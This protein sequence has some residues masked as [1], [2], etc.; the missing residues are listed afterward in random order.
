LFN[1]RIGL[2]TVLVRLR[3]M[4]GE[5]G[6]SS[7]SNGLFVRMF[8]QEFSPNH[9]LPENMLTLTQAKTQS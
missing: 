9:S 8:L 4:A 2:G 1:W 5:L 7:L 3:K 6:D